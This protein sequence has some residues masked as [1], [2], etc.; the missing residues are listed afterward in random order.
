MLDLSWI[1]GYQLKYFITDSFI[2]ISFFS[3]KVLYYVFLMPR[4]LVHNC[5]QLF[6]LHYGLY[7]ND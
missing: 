7:H 2:S 3:L 5:S 1:E 6:K 4:Y